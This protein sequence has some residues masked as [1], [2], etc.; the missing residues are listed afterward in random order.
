MQNLKIE[1][2]IIEKSNQM[3]VFTTMVSNEAV[4]EKIT[5]IL[6]TP[7]EGRPENWIVHLEQLL[8]VVYNEGGEFDISYKKTAKA[9]TVDMLVATEPQYASALVGIL[10]HNGRV[11]TS[12]EYVNGESKTILFGSVSA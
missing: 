2:H 9:K 12:I 8:D 1:S 11:L 5:E 4:I 10:F 6:N 3:S 7:I